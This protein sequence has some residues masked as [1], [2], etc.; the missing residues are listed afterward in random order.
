MDQEMHRCW[1]LA[2]RRIDASLAGITFFVLWCLAIPIT[3]VLTELSWSYRFSIALVAA[4]PLAVILVGVFL[5][6]LR[7]VHAIEER[8]EDEIERWRT[9]GV[10][11]REPNLLRARQ[12]RDHYPMLFVIALVNFYV[13][14]LAATRLGHAS[15]R[16]L[17]DFTFGVLLVSLGIGL[18][19]I[20]LATSLTPRGKT[21]A[22]ILVGWPVPAGVFFCA[23]ALILGSNEI[24]REV[25]LPTMTAI[26]Y[27]ILG[28]IV[29]LLG[30]SVFALWV[31]WLV[32]AVK[33]DYLFATL[34][35]FELAR[36]VRGSGSNLPNY[37]VPLHGDAGLGSGGSVVVEEGPK[38]DDD[39]ASVSTPPG[40]V[41]GPGTFLA[42]PEF[43]EVDVEI[44]QEAL[45]FSRTD[46]LL[47]LLILV[48]TAVILVL[49]QI[50]YA[51]TAYHGAVAVLLL[52]ATLT[53]VYRV[54]QVF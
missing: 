41:G 10:L 8:D 50:G 53:Y 22:L 2:E 15:Y 27:V 44:V 43:D 17:S 51:G 25:L 4:I 39:A 1:L 6:S 46:M 18:C 34:P 52:G 16:A 24:S 20:V 35:S 31:A 47:A 36:M 12:R 30:L 21:W 5:S 11:P 49:S 38:N 23:T 40:P 3:V 9:T 42:P 7:V 45:R 54:W 28:A 19:A 26:V 13:T 14:I 32:R 29:A 33:G 37:D 48:S